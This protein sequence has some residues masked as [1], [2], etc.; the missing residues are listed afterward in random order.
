MFHMKEFIGFIMWNLNLD[1]HPLLQHR[2]KC[3]EFKKITVFLSIGKCHYGLGCGVNWLNFSMYYKQPTKKNMSVFCTVTDWPWV[4]HW[5][6]VSGL[7]R[8]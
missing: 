8:E 4:N 2:V 7:Q 1:I 5:R 6:D 3:L